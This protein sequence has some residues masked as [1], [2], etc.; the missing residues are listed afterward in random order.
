MQNAD[1]ETTKTPPKKDS[2]KAEKKNITHFW[3]EQSVVRGVL[4]KGCVI[5]SSKWQMKLKTEDD[6]NNHGRLGVPRRS[7]DNFVSD[8][9]RLPW[10]SRGGEHPQCHLTTLNHRS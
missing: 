9:R 3:G 4:A 7:E 10:R 2:E 5:S 8:R 6:N 1:E